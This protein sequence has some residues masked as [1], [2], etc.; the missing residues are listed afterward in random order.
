MESEEPSELNIFP[1]FSPEGSVP[2]RLVNVGDGSQEGTEDDLGVVLEE[3]DLDGA[4]GEVHHHSSAGPEPG[5]QGG[6]PGQ[7][8]LLPHLH[9][10]ARLQQVLLH[11]VPEVVQEL[12]LLLDCGGELVHG[13]V[14][15]K[16]GN[17]K[18]KPNTSTKQT[19]FPSKSM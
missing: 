18:T 10:G 3:V 11:V 15:L 16:C 2:P 7:L 13:V 9:V 4:V 14:V 12:H 1:H 5:L 19:S 8:I 17:I 6:D